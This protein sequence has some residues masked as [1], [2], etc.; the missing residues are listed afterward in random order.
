VYPIPNI[1]DILDSLRQSKIFC[2]LDMVSGFHQIAIKPKHKGK[3]AFSCHRCH[4]QFVKMPFGLNDAPAT[5]QW[6]IDV[7]L[8]S[9]K[10]IDCLVT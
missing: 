7:I 3:T 2:V 1:V 5:Y 4:F 6:C 9:L 10:G 8:M